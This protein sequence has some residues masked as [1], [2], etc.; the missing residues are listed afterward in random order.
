MLYEAG[1]TSLERTRRIL[2][3]STTASAVV[4]SSSVALFALI[5][6]LDIGTMVSSPDRLAAAGPDSADLVRLWAVTDLVGYFLLF[7]IVVLAVRGMFWLRGSRRMNLHAAAGIAYILIGGFASLV[8]AANAP[9][10]IADV[11]ATGGASAP[12]AARAFT[13][14]T[15]LVFGLFWQRLATIPAGIWWIGIALLVG[16]TLPVLRALAWLT[17]ALALLAAAG[18]W[19]GVEVVADWLTVG[20][21]LVWIPAVLVLGRSFRG[22]S[23]DDPANDPA[24][25]SNLDPG[26]E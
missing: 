5:T 12:V 17:G 11:A 2:V 13:E 1:G 23:F 14:L 18:A 3:R 9:S 20:W 6:R 25:G 15:D 21:V 24:A 8:F 22:V 7:G 4:A 16:S 19:L 26:P 10:L